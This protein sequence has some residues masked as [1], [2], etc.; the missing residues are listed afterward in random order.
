M[1][2][3]LGDEQLVATS[4]EE[5]AQSIPVPDLQVPGHLFWFQN[6]M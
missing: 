3:R 6:R 1:V 4:S 5:D 2:G